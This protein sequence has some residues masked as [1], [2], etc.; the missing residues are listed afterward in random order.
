MSVQVLE[1]RDNSNKLIVA[2][3]EPEASLLVV[4]P[5]EDS[6]VG[7]RHFEEEKAKSE[8]ISLSVED[9]GKI[10][11]TAENLRKLDHDDGAEA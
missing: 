6:K 9:L 3:D 5:G 7:T 1:S 11:Y 4:D 10:L 2:V 8:D